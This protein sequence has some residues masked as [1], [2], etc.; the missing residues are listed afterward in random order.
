MIKRVNS[1]YTFA[2]VRGAQTLKR[3]GQILGEKPEYLTELAIQKNSYYDPYIDKKPGKKPRPIDQPKGELLRI[4]TK[5]RDRLLDL[6]PLCKVTYGGVVG[7]DTKSAASQHLQKDVL[8]K[9]DL[10]DCFHS[11]KARMVRRLFRNRFGFS[12]PV[13][14]LLTELCTYN[15]HVP[16]GS[17]LS[18]ALVNNVLNPVWVKIDN[19]CAVRDLS[20]T[21]WVDDLAISGKCADKV[22]EMIKRCINSYGYKISWN[23]TEVLRRNK[24]Q[25]VTGN[26]VNTKQVT[27]PKQKRREIAKSITQNPL[28]PSTNGK[29][30]YAEITNQVQ[31]RQ[32]TKLRSRISAAASK[33]QE[34]I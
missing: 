23:K 16:V 19:E 24:P 11:T 10:R 18:S 29:V 30:N 34:A 17:T 25:V 33:A 2:Q 3:I 31:A 12:K 22:I 32:L 26:G 6:I 8:V 1:P 28:S 21:T 14:D 20:F 4:Q 27:I 7:K 5:I 9:L 15:G 13:S